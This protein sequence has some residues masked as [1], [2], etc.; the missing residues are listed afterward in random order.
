VTKKRVFRD[1]IEEKIG[2]I[3]KKIIETKWS[4]VFSW[5]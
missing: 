1:V 2:K 4:S 5:R 3:S